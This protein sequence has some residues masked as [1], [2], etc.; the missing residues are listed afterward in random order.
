MYNKITFSISLFVLCSLNIYAQ[1]PSKDEL[2][3]AVVKM[4]KLIDSHYVFPE[5][6]KKT[7][8]HIIETHKKGYFD[9][10][11]TWKQFD[12]LSSKIIREYSQDGHM[13]V[14]YDPKTVKELSEVKQTVSES[15]SEDPF[16]YGP[17]AL[18]NNFGFKEVKILNNNIGYIKLDEINTSERSL[19]V[20]YASME[21]VSNTDAL[22]IDLKN[23]GGGGSSIGNV[24]E[25]FFLPKETLLLEFKKRNGETRLSKTAAWMTQKK[26]TKPLFILTNNATFS[27]AEALAYGL[28]Q[29]NRAKVVGQRSG[30]GAHMNSWYPVNKHIY[31]SVSTGAP[32]LPGTEKSWEGKG[33]QPDYVVDEGKELE[34]IKKLL[35]NLHSN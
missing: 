9:K 27:A 13:Y 7:A 1:V 6:G 26:Y 20:L 19:A 16:Y 21:F 30:G 31:L 23:N 14:S 17:D 8:N 3:L 24:I 10:V 4:S 11:Q 15:F 28:Q 5:K 2:Q 33:V 35:Q 29:T 12:S 18:K 22:I 25:S 32:T 34:L